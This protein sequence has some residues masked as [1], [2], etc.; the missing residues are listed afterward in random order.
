MVVP[1]N[2]R[3]LALRLF[4]ILCTLAGVVFLWAAVREAWPAN[5]LAAGLAALVLGTMSGL[6]GGFATFDPDSLLLTLWCAGMWLG[7]RDWRARRCSGW[8]V[9]AL[10]AATCVSSVAV[11]A[12]LAAVLGLGWR[13]GLHR[14]VAGRLAARAR[15]DG[16]LGRVEPARLRQRLAAQR[17]VHRGPPAPSTGAR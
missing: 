10:T 11:P 2:H 14:R 3:V 5:P 13:A 16:R 8:T 4:S 7:L 12:A 6:V 1:W 9:A 15:P 17:L